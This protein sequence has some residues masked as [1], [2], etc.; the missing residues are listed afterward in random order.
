[1]PGV[2]Q[3]VV[4]YTG[5]ANDSPSYPSVCAGDGHSEALQLE[6]DEREQ[7]YEELVDAFFGMHVPNTAGKK[8]YRSA[9]LYHDQEQKEIAEKVAERRD[10]PKS[11]GLL[12]PATPWHD[13]EEYH[14]KYAQKQMAFWGD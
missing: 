4:G 7:S 13:A 8:Q 6:F 11:S 10:Y 1:M 9:I 14:Q 5:G 3:S 2:K 12:Q